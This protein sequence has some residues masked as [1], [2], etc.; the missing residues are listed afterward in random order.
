MI[1][2]FINYY[3]RNLKFLIFIILISLIATFYTNK[4]IN[5][6]RNYTF[7]IER[8]TILQLNQLAPAETLLNILAPGK[9]IIS[10]QGVIDEKIKSSMSIISNAIFE[11][12]IN[13]VTDFSYKKEFLKNNPKIINYYV[14]TNYSNWAKITFKTKYNEKKIINTIFFNDFINSSNEITKELILDL[15]N[16][17]SSNSKINMDN[18]DKFYKIKSIT[19][20]LDNKINSF[21]IFFIFFFILNYLYFLFFYFTNSKIKLKI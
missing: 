21:Y 15:L 3:F 13:T 6:Y 4:T 20:A 18:I 11:N 1:N 12:V 8:L 2:K 14:K 7:E 9:T 19:I 10:P 17:R 16:N 5:K